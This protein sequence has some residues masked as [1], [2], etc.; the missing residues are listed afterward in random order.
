M[1]K[2]KSFFSNNRYGLL[3]ACILLFFL[4]LQCNNSEKLKKSITTISS[5]NSQYK[6]KIG[7]LT[8]RSKVLQVDNDNLKKYIAK[9]DTLKKLAKP[10]LKIETITKVKT[11]I[12]FDTI[13]TVFKQTIP[14]AFVRDSS[15]VQKW[16]A[17]KY[18]IDNKK[19]DIIDLYIP[20]EQTAIT[21]FQRKWMLGKQ[22]YVTEITNTNPYINTLEVESVV[23][24]VPVEWY[25]SK[26]I[27]FSAGFIAN[28]LIINS[29]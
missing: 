17:F 21:G 13:R 6:N 3:L 22:T 24:V 11:V 25:N 10:F 27:W 5:E 9:N 4:V 29:R 19:F 16:Y 2:I 26:L 12:Q 23:K 14:C 7:T 8:T 28:S 18:K 20:N 1:Q 15:K